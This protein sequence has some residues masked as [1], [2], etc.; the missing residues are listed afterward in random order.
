VV[1]TTWLHWFSLTPATL[2]LVGDAPS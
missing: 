2:A 1:V